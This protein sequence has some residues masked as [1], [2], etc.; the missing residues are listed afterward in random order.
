MKTIPI[1]K[2]RWGAF[3]QSHPRLQYC[4]HSRHHYSCRE[5]LWAKK[6]GDGCTT[7]RNERPL[8]LR[9]WPGFALCPLFPPHRRRARRRDVPPRN[10]PEICLQRRAPVSVDTFGAPHSRCLTHPDHSCLLI[11]RAFVK[12]IYLGGIALI[13]CICLLLDELT[14]PL[15]QQGQLTA[16][17]VQRREVS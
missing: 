16:L 7:W 15:P 12:R 2:P 4:L 9:V 3:A 14:C 6:Q 1:R 8:L 5:L 10:H 13:V 11:A 17:S